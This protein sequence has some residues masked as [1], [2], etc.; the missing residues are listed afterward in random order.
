MKPLAA[1][2]LLATWSAAAAWSQSASLTC[3]PTAVPALVHREGIAERAGDIVLACTSGAVAGT[4]SGNLT[5]FLSTNVTNRLNGTTVTGVSA[6]ID[7][8]PSPLA[9]TA[10][11]QSPTAVSFHS[12]SIPVTAFQGLNLRISGLRVNA[13]QT[14][15]GLLPQPITAT[16][17]FNGISLLAGNPAVVVALPAPA[18][19]GFTV[20]DAGLRFTEKFASSF[21]GRLTAPAGGADTGTRI[22]VQFSGFPPGVTLTVPNAIA[23]SSAATPTASGN[24][25]TAA[26]GGVYTPGTP[27]GSLLLSL[28]AAADANGAGGAPVFTPT[29]TAPI[30]LSG[31]T[32]VALVNGAG[33]AVYEVIDQNPSVRESAQFGFGFTATPGCC[34]PFQA[35]VSASLAPVSTVFQADVTAPIPRFV[36]TPAGGDCDDLQDCNAD[37]FPHLSVSPLSVNFTAPEGGN[38]VFQYL[39]VRNTGGGALNFTPTITYGNGSGWLV[40]DPGMYK[41]SALPAGLAP[42]VYQASLLIDAGPMA[43]SKTVVVTLT[44]TAAPPNPQ[45]PVVAAV[46]NAA[47]YLQGPLQPGSFATIFGSRLAPQPAVAFDELTGT[48][49]F[50]N[51]QQINVLLPAG[52][53]GRSSTKMTVT[54]VHGASPAFPLTLAPFAPGIFGALNQDFRLNTSHR[55][56]LSGSILQLFLTGAAA[57]AGTVTTVK[58]QDQ[59]NLVPDYAGD[60]PGIPGLQQVNVVIPATLPTAESQAV[61]CLAPSAGAPRVCSPPLTIWVEHP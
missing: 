36:L 60:A 8:Q 52:L 28:V 11:L 30:T 14:G 35:Q 33:A 47:N 10:V 9:T 46:V 18:S 38:P 39:Q 13:T 15:G 61:V 27:G 50:A 12:I 32:T 19:L 4:V 43:G 5:L 25:G 57:P 59:D 24:F 23:G 55:P 34:Q 17:S 29:G 26:T 44:V 40:F 6:G 51:N 2:L 54:T 41:L 48:V 42:G 3:A 49:V 16:L 1:T 53:Q 45:A 22:L 31:A 56:A 37:Y 20:Q 21:E 7:G 58:I